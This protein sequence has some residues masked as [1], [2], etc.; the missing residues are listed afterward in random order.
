M[1]LIK[2]NLLASTQ[3]V[4]NGTIF[5][6]LYNEMYILFINNYLNKRNIESLIFLFFDYNISYCYEIFYL[7]VFLII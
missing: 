3:I 4:F 2:L 5:L 7:I 1:I 6:I